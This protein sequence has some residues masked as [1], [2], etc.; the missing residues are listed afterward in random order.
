VAKPDR[1]PNGR[2]LVPAGIDEIVHRFN[3]AMTLPMFTCS[4]LT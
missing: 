4:P 3:P 1:L 2:R